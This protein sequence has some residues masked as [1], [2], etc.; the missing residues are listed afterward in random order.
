MKRA[1]LN[2]TLLLFLAAAAPWASSQAVDAAPAAVPAVE[3]RTQEAVDL[4]SGLNQTSPRAA[5]RTFLEAMDGVQRSRPGAMAAALECLYLEGI[6]ARER[7]A[8]GP[9]AARRL[10]DILGGVTLRL[11]DLPS[12]TDERTLDITLDYPEPIVLTLRH[13]DDGSWRFNSETIAALPDLYRQYE[14]HRRSLQDEAS[15]LNLHPDLESPRK[16][17]RTFLEGMHAWSDGGRDRVLRTMDLSAEPEAVRNRRGEHYA[18]LLK[19]VL[20]RYPAVVYE[21]IPDHRTGARY[22]HVLPNIRLEEGRMV[23]GEIHIALIEHDTP[24]QTGWRFT[25]ETLNRLAG[26]YD[27]VSYRPRLAGLQDG[28]S[29]SLVM[30][31]RDTIA[32]NYPPLLNRTLILE[33]WQW[34]ALFLIIFTGMLVSRLFVTVLVLVLRTIYRRRNLVFDR[35][36]V[37]RF[38]LPIR[39]TFMAWVWLLGLNLLF[40]PAWVESMLF[41]AVISI[42]YGGAIWAAYKLVDLLGSYLTGLASKSGSRYDSLL[43]PLLIRSLKI[44]VIVIGATIIT[45]EAYP[46]SYPQIIAGL[47]IGGVAIAFAARDTIANLFGSVMI[48]LDRPF[49]IG[50]WINVRGVDGSVEQ[51]G[52]RSTRIRT[53]YDSLV[54]VP[55]SEIALATIDNY[56]ARR[57]RRIRTTLAVTYDTPPEKIE[58]FCEG[59][60]EL[61]RQHP[62]TR[63]DFYLVYLNEFGPHSLDILL[64]CFHKTPDWSTELRERHRLFL[65]IIRLARELGVEFAFPTRTLYMRPEEA[66]DAE[67]GKADHRY[68]AYQ[69]GREHATEI[70]RKQSGGHPERIPPPVKFDTPDGIDAL[71][72][73]SHGDDG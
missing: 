27:A 26:Y 11:D 72:E 60:R 59:I 48:L 16:T 19:E 53:F 44:F 8:A 34:A 32:R 45:Y 37:R 66:P 70:H 24:G 2:L 64:Y 31:V 57:Y 73:S 69:Q 62:Y 42:T 10:H 38:A 7:P 21:T 20:D 23:D 61:I 46:H 52:I 41:I 49:E 68:A 15:E 51:V 25:P 47:G 54:T 6:P 50:D 17:M 5:V 9:D 12:E 1:T 55:N 65:D 36:K 35:E 29:L 39:L 30:Q 71:D 18:S 33:N 43:V 40:L 63:K 22:V 13:Y 56:G 14:E 67:A 58:A 28:R 4:P 3:E